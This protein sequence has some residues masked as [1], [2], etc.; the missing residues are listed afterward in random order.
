MNG[1]S[2]AR[3]IGD[4]LSLLSL[5][6]AVPAVYSF[7]VG[8]GAAGALF[9][10]CG[11]TMGAGLLLSGRFAAVGRLSGIKI[12]GGQRAPAKGPAVAETR[13]LRAR[14][15]GPR[16]FAAV[17][18]GWLAVIGAGSLPFLLGADVPAVDALFESASA[19]TTTGA[20]ALPSVR[21]L[22][23]SLLFWRSL[24]QWL[25]GMGII[26]L[27]LSVFPRLGVDGFAQFRAE[28]PGPAPTKA[29]PRLSASSRLLWV[30]YIALTMAAFFALWATGLTPFDA[31][32]FALATVS[33]GG[34]STLDEGP[35]GFSPGAQWVLVLFMFLGGTNF[36]LFHRMFRFDRRSGSGKDG[37]FVAYARLLLVAGAAIAASLFLQS[38]WKAGAALRVGLFQAVS[39]VTTTGYVLDDYGTW[40]AFAQAIVF[41]GLFVGGSAGSTAGGPK[42]ARLL[43]AGKYAVQQLRSF[44]HPRS[45]TVLRLGGATI[46]ETVVGQTL[47][48]LILYFTLF[49]IGTVGLAAL[50]QSL[51]DAAAA[52]AAALGN[53]GTGFGATGPGASHASFGPAEKMW[54]AAFMIVGRLEILAVLALF[55]SATSFFR[56]VRGDL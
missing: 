29:L 38:G 46:P 40:P 48:F 11:I 23:P 37:E 22:P 55:Q 15:A 39:T 35:A 13:L 21:L 53:V 2:S 44:V 36:A 43:I 8:D 52:S 54:L 3:Q 56:R 18:S 1:R 12:R 24:L 32:N 9:A 6:M 27:L 51:P 7:L 16:A 26:V 14:V 28:V 19:F 42:V 31:M 34:F 25:G 20:S 41:F 17:A 49:C 50:G 45:V 33:T 5:F 10:S 47:S 4:L 30:I